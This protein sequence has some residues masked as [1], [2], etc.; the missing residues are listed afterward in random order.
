M[1][2]ALT[3]KGLP[4]G[5]HTCLPE[6]V[7][8]EKK[9]DID[10]ERER[11]TWESCCLHTDRQ[12]PIYIGQL[13]FSFAILGF[14]AGMLVAA[15]GDCNQSSPYIGLISFLM[16]YDLM[17][18]R[19]F[20]IKGSFHQSENFPSLRILQDLRYFPR[21]KIFSQLQKVFF[22]APRDFFMGPQN[23]YICVDSA[24]SQ[25]PITWCNMV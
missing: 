12:A 5:D 2:A 15:D 25:V 6:H 7:L 23:I 22:S 9:I 11:R 14:S 3:A 20:L 24:G 16:S 21:P 17:K 19:V 10:A 8:E 4:P 13:V 1:H 18:P